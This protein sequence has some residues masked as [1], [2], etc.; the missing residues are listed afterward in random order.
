MEGWRKM[1]LLMVSAWDDV[2]EPNELRELVDRDEADEAR[3]NEKRLRMA[4]KRDEV[5]ILSVGDGWIVRGVR[6][7]TF[8]WL[9]GRPEDAR[10]LRGWNRECGKQIGAACVLCRSE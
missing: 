1:T 2:L 3:R 9:A 6:V 5:C 10:S 8:G 4:W 7:D